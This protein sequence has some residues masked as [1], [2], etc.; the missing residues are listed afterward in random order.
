MGLIELFKNYITPTLMRYLA[1][2]TVFHA[3]L[4]LLPLREGETLIALYFTAIG[5]YMASAVYYTLIIRE[6]YRKGIP[7]FETLSGLWVNSISLT[8]LNIITVATNWQLIS[9]GVVPFT[10]WNHVT[11][12]IYS[13][14][15]WV[16]LIVAFE[17]SRKK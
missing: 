8:A 14:S 5:V 9:S 1:I 13:Y 15:A 11:T 12:L 17:G 2:A 4:Y 3:L 10:I 16:F 7:A 6:R